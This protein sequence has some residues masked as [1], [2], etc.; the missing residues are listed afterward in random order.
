MTNI[1]LDVYPQLTEKKSLNEVVEAC[2]NF[3]D[4]QDFTKDEKKAI[5]R[6]CRLS[7]MGIN[8]E[9]KTP[10]ETFSVESD[11]TNNEFQLVV[12]RAIESYNEKDLSV[13]KEALNKLENDDE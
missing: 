13:V 5:T 12:N 7:I 1:L 10:L 3:T 11:T 4:E 9:D 2:E 8:N 6:L